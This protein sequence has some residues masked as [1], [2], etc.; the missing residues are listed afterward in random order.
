MCRKIWQCHCAQEGKLTV[1]IVAYLKTITRINKKIHI[2]QALTCPEYII[3]ELICWSVTVQSLLTLV[4]LR[5]R[6]VILSNIHAHCHGRA[7]HK[8]NLGYREHAYVLCYL[9]TIMYPPCN[10]SNAISTNNFPFLSYLHTKRSPTQSDIYQRLYWYN[11]LSWWWALGCSKHVENWNKYIEKNC[12]SIWSLTMKSF[13]IK[14]IT[15][16]Y[17]RNRGMEGKCR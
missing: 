7:H 12:A 11:W 9:P 2:S 4:Q 1:E 16:G 15:G 8:P 17:E 10:S 3:V 14:K 5:Q 13:T 6:Q